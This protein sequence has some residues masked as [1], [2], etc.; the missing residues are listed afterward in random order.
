MID[1][2]Q[3]ADAKGAAAETSVHVTV[4]EV[5]MSTE[6]AAS[7]ADDAASAVERGDTAGANA[8]V[9]ASCCWTQ[10]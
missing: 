5:I 2:L 7:V 3:V 1:R 4:A 8:A 9:A 6:L 10:R